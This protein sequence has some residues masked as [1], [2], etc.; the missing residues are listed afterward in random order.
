MEG[1]YERIIYNISKSGPAN[2]CG[3][4][5]YVASVFQ[6]Q[7][8]D[9]SVYYFATTPFFEVYNE[10]LQWLTNHVFVCKAIRETDAVKI[11]Y[12]VIE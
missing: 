8:A 3:T 7:F 2:R 1:N 10:E 6:G 5:Q 4:G 11:K 12:F 9:S